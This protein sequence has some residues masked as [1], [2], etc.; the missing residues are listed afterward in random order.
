M[1]LAGPADPEPVVVKCA[2]S[3]RSRPAYDQKISR[4]RWWCLFLCRTEAD[5]PNGMYTC[6]L[7]PITTP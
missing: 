6:P 7:N 3:E 5:D 4:R 2:G 1:D